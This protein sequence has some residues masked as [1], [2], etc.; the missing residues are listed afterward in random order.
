MAKNEWKIRKLLALSLFFLLPGVTI[1]AAAEIKV[2]SPGAVQPAVAGLAEAFQRETGHEIKFTF[3]NVGA[4]QKKIEAG[5][6]ADIYILSDVAID[7]LVKKG[8]V[9]DG[10][11]TAIARIGIGVAV[12]EGAPIPDISTPEALKRTLLSAKSLVYMDPS[13]GGTSAIHFA[14][15]IEQLG[16]ADA[17]KNKTVLWP[18]GFA[19][20]ALVKGEAEICVHNISEII[21]VKGVTLVGPLPREVQKVT[22]YSAA[23]APEAVSS[24]ACKAFVQFLASPTARSKFAAAGLDYKE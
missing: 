9:A 16:I 18:A 19:A 10:T 15:V 2:M 24:D 22:T 1:A 17:L 11:R 20:E 6:R 7:A 3:D 8:I 5:E 13:K 4:L 12:L 21:A 14:K 23:F